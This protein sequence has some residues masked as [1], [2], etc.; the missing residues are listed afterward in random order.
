M[1]ESHPEVGNHRKWDVVVEFEAFLRGALDRRVSDA[2]Q[3]N[4]SP[5]LTKLEEA[6]VTSKS[7]CGESKDS[8]S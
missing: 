6:C 5:S 2:N 7:T 8:N 1:D 3:M 4:K